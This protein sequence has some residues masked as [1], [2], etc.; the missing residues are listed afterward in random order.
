MIHFRHPNPSN[1]DEFAKSVAI[2]GLVS[3][4]LMHQLN[5]YAL[6][7]NATCCVSAGDVVVAGAPGLNSRKGERLVI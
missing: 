4:L 7:T 2:S 6:M 3:P 5:L 1:Q